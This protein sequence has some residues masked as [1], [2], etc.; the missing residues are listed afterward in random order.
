M[1]HSVVALNNLKKNTLVE[2]N[3]KARP[4]NNKFNC[5]KVTRNIN[6]NS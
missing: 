2:I 5:I 4:G 3:L 1:C 6:N